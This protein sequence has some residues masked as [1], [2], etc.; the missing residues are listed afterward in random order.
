MSFNW[1]KKIEPTKATLTRG[2]FRQWSHVTNNRMQKMI[3]V[4]ITTLKIFKQKLDSW[5]HF[6]EHDKQRSRNS[7][8]TWCSH[9]PHS[10]SCKSMRYSIL[11]LTMSTDTRILILVNHWRKRLFS[12]VCSI[13]NFSNDFPVQL[14]SVFFLST[15]IQTIMNIYKTH[16]SFQF[17]VVPGIWIQT[18]RKI[19]K[20]HHQITDV[21]Y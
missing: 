18:K 12:V 1:N 10:F 8:Q 15:N 7:K 14:K 6:D 3:A 2:K 20:T 5:Q 17:I 11:T 13:E 19:N 21:E 4:Y 9:H 16:N